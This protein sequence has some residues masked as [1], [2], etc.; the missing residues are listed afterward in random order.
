MHERPDRERPQPHVQGRERDRQRQSADLVP[1]RDEGFRRR[2]REREDILAR[3]GQRPGHD[4]ARDGEP[5]AAAAPHPPR[6]E[7]LEVV[8]RPHE[9]GQEGGG[10]EL[11]VEGDE[12][13]WV[14]HLQHR[15]CQQSL[16]LPLLSELSHSNVTTL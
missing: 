6:E 14:D 1:V 16:S 2:P 7:S 5:P 13:G 4:A 15:L 10:R 9:Q 11:A 8:A 3:H 12:V